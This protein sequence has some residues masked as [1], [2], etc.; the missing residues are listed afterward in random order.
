MRNLREDELTERKVTLFAA[1]VEYIHC[2]NKNKSNSS[3][4]KFHYI[5]IAKKSKSF[6]DDAC[7]GCIRKAAE[8]ACPNKQK[9][10]KTASLSANEEADRANDM[11]G[12]IP[13]PL[14]EKC[15]HFVAYSTATDNSLLFS[16]EV[17]M[18]TFI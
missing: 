14:K 2:C 15:K 6:T 5:R 17:L 3:F 13:R 7:V 11:T 12:G 10:Y 8:T 1:A 4:G 16:F 18:G 9:L